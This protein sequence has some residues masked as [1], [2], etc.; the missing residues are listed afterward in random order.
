MAPHI[1]RFTTAYKTPHAKVIF[2]IYTALKIRFPDTM[3]KFVQ[4]KTGTPN[5]VPQDISALGTFKTGDMVIVSSQKGQQLDITHI[6][7]FSNDAC[8][9]AVGNQFNMLAQAG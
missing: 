2:N 6:L 1:L 8:T 7:Q 9:K 5:T 3:G 4:S